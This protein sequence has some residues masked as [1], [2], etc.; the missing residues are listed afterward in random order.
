VPAGGFKL[1]STRQAFTGWR[2]VGARGNV[3]VVSSRYRGDGI[4]FNAESGAQWMD[5]TGFESNMA[6]GVAESVATTRGTKYHLTF[7]VGNVY[8]PGGIFG[9]SSTVE[10][11][12]NGVRS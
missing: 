4:T 12:V 6:T 10:V 2:V 7:W 5:L 1:F 8:D 9:V 3:G 11:Y